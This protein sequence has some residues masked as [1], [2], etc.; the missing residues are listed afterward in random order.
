MANYWMVRSDETIRDLVEDGG[1]VAIGFGGNVIGDISGLSSRDAIREQVVKRRPDA[2]PG[3]IRS[4]TSQLFR[5]A[6]EIRVGDWVLTG[7][8]DRQYLIGKIT[9]DYR[10]DE[11]SPGQ[12][13]RRSVDWHPRRLNRDDMTPYLKN[14][15][16]GQ[17]TL[18]NITK[19]ASEISSLLGEK[20]PTNQAVE[21]VGFE[22][23]EEFTEIAYAED[24]EAKAH[25][26]IT[27]LILDLRRFDGHE[28]ERLVAALLEAM[29]FKIVREPQGGADGGVDI[30]AAPDVFGFE[31]PRIIVQV[32]HR[33]G[34][35]GEGDVQRLAEAL[36]PGEKGL[37][38]STGGFHPS[39]KR[40]A[41]Q[42]MTLLDG[43]KVVDYFIE[44]YES[45][46]SEYKAKVPLKRVYIPVPPDEV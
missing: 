37:F 15:L 25:E 32:K 13:Y 21:S 9:S 12:P 19:H 46:S 34:R 2:R 30:I 18:F 4:D 44:H 28:F 17:A 35:V 29:G 38:V 20:L 26:R 5:F 42:N 27:D 23:P 43:D 40:M 10:F 1:F 3:Q 31:Q 33:E 22:D 8:R 45:M 24:T 36:Q 7:V 11:S 39:A 41:D 6:R 14:S 16:G